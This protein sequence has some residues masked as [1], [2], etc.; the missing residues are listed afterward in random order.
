[1]R[2]RVAADGRA[3]GSAGFREP[4]RPRCG[5]PAPAPRVAAAYPRRCVPRQKTAAS[6][7]AGRSTAA[8]SSIHRRHATISCARAVLERR[9]RICGRRA[10][11]DRH[12]VRPCTTSYTAP[13]RARARGAITVGRAGACTSLIRRRCRGAFVALGHH[14]R[15]RGANRHLEIRPP[16]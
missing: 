10:R 6:F 8:G 11:A 12:R 1:L 14:D 9:D 16:P 2:D 5:G 13:K 4:C 3:Q 15:A 7:N